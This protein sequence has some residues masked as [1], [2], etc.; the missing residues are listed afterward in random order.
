MN[1]VS[2][3]SFLLSSMCFHSINILF[4]LLNNSILVLTFFNGQTRRKDCCFSP[5]INVN[6]Q[7]A[8]AGKALLQRLI[9][10]ADIQE[11]I[12]PNKICD[13]V[14]FLFQQASINKKSIPFT[15]GQFHKIPL[16][17]NNES[18]KECSLFSIHPI[19]YS[20]D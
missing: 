1:K 17:K 6:S 20:I 18:S 14:H 12:T 19:E 16:E 11:E 15:E 3:F 13:F 5:K 2:Q 9:I 4:F 8:N 7:K 10:P